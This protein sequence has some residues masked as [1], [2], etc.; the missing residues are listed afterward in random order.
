MTID[1]WRLP[2]GR[3]RLRPAGLIRRLLRRPG[4]VPLDYEAARWYRDGY[5]GSGAPD[6]NEASDVLR[7]RVDELA[8]ANAL[9]EGSAHV[10]DAT[11]D[12]WATEWTNRNLAEHLARQNILQQRENQAL[13]E[14]ARLDTLAGLAAR[15]LAEVEQRLRWLHAGAEPS[16]HPDWGAEPGPAPEQH[17]PDEE[18]PPR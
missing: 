7:A 16:R 13:A 18:E 11:V 10:F 4:A 5:A 14:V 15:R 3:L 9:D 6:P 17:V 2:S 1:T 8:R 12:A